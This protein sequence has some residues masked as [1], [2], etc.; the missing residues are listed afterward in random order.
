MTLDERALKG[1]MEESADLQS[2]AMATTGASLQEMVDTAAERRG[3][4]DLEANRAFA[5][6]RRET[7]SK[8]LA[9]IGGLAVGGLGTALLAAVASP[10][11]ADSS[12]DIQMMQTAAS[13]ENLAVA[14]YKTALTLPFIGGSS[15]NGVVKAFATTTM[16]QHAQHAQAFNSAATSL[17]GKSQP[18]PDPKYAAVVKAAVPT[19]KGPA[20]VVGLA[21]KLEMVA[22]QTYVADVSALSDLN[23]R[24][25]TA[26]IM[27]VEAQ[28]VSILL[29]V[30]ALLAANAP[31]LIALPPN[32]A[33]LPGAAGSLGFPDAFYPTTL[34]SPASE[35][36][37][38]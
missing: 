5:A 30:Q 4:D 16:S 13:I 37:V 31:Q 9:G 6:A 1:L 3:E 33:A 22:A 17:G 23:A 18:N 27:G 21:L 38:S 8:T 24:K 11:M 26:S 19:I 35:G 2:D 10:A 32:A 34:A 20:D 12:M 14:T 28:H 25:T 29:A 36:A 15:A 7:M